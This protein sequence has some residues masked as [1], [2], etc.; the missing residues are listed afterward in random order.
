MYPVTGFYWELWVLKVYLDIPCKR[1]GVNVYEMGT[2]CLLFLECKN[3]FGTSSP[4]KVLVL[5][6]LSRPPDKYYFPIPFAMFPNQSISSFYCLS[7]LFCFKHAKHFHRIIY[8]YLQYIN[9]CNYESHN[10][11]QNA[12]IEKGI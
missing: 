10:I 7:H 8:V 2:I 11:N 4:M 6:I 3:I 12:R 1:I 9:I 5:A